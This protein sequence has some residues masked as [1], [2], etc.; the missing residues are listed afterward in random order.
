MLIGSQ[1][2]LLAGCSYIQLFGSFF[3]VQRISLYFHSQSCSAFM[4]FKNSKTNSNKWLVFL[5]ISSKYS[6]ALLP[7]VMLLILLFNSGLK[8]KTSR[9]T[10]YLSSIP[11][12]YLD[13]QRFQLSMTFQSTL[14]FKL[15]GTR[16]Q[17]SKVFWVCVLLRY[18]QWAQFGGRKP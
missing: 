13:C 4:L 2:H 5:G 17:Y 9:K 8:R 10:S 6:Y 7:L 3:K 12:Y 18:Q 14:H 1:Q 15:M 16:N 11:K